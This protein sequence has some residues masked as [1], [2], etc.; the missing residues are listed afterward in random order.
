MREGIL[1]TV[2]FLAVACEYIGIIVFVTG[3]IFLL[4]HVGQP[5][6]QMFAG[7]GVFFLGRVLFKASYR[8]HLRG[9]Q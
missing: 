3:V 9:K 5:L 7:A 2:G 6:N 4:F 1:L 8:E